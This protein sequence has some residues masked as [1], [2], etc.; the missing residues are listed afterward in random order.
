VTLTAD[1]FGRCSV[2]REQKGTENV[3]IG[4]RGDP[5]IAERITFELL[6]RE[7]FIGIRSAVRYLADYIGDSSPFA[8]Q[9]AR[10]PFRAL[11]SGKFA[12]TEGI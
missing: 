1:G 7:R 11:L 8:R 9:L 3:R 6:G 10:A 12:A 4:R 5:Y 2:T